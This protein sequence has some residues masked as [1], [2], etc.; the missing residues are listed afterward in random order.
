[1]KH[2]GPMPRH[3]SRPSRAPSDDRHP[4]SF[5]MTAFTAT[6]RRLAAAGFLVAGLF[7]AT[8]PAAA[9]DIQEITT[10]GGLTAWLVQDD[11][12]PIVAIKFAF[13]G[14]ASQDPD[15]KEGLANLLSA[16]LDEGAGDLDSQAF[17]TRLEDLSVRI[18]FDTGRDNFYGSLRTLTPNIDDAFE[19]LR[20]AV[21][22]PRFDTDAVERMKRQIV[23]GLRREAN[24]PDAIAG[25]VWAEAAFPGHPYGRPSS[26]T[27]DSVTALSPEDLAAL[28]GRLFARK[29]LK[30]SVVGAIGPERLAALLDSV[31]GALPEA[32]ELVAVADT[33]LS[34][35]GERKSIALDVPQTSIR[36]GLPALKR[37]D[38]DFIP[39]FVMNHILGGGSFSSWLY[40]EVREK[41]GLAYSVGSYLIPYEHAGLW[42]AATGTRSDR[43]EETLAIIQAQIARMVSEGPSAEELAKA[44]AYMTGSYALRF[45]TSDKIAD[46]LLGLQVEELGMDYI[47]TRNSLIEAVT[48]EDVRRVADRLL[49]D[50][51]PLVVTVGSGAS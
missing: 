2:T 34:P 16:T 49:K 18:G 48:L 9:M 51:R 38:P 14:G 32:G 29:D 3:G 47:D 15:G 35:E 17:Q 45:D 19:M 21:N 24:D 40:E 8:L 28:H 41:R 30:I 13:A 43:A 44:K 46:Q 22:E 11:T 27:Q 20:L 33:A 7:A 1:M 10:P 23:S 36:L 4:G 37:D 39:A 26:G 25:R 31:F 5:P 6:G 42:M 12:V 50:A